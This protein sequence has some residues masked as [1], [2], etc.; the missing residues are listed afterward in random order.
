M[1]CYK[2][3]TLRRGSLSLGNSTLLNLIDCF[4]ALDT[5]GNCQRPDFSLGVSQYLHKIANLRKFELNWLSELR[6]NNG[7]N[8]THVP[9]C[10]RSDAWFRDLSWDLKIN[11]NILVRN[12]LFL[13]N[14]ITSEGAISFSQCVILSTA[15]HCL[16]PSKFVRCV[17]LRL[18]IVFQ[19]LWCKNTFNLLLFS[20]LKLPTMISY[21]MSKAAV[22]QFTRC[23]A[24][25]RSL[26]VLL[27]IYI[28]YF[29]YCLLVL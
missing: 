22:T 4:K 18:P 20:V 16:L 6:E 12:Y 26:F 24:L 11:S 1:P 15:L 14:Y 19:C 5:F 27:C 9:S 29:T 13:K 17:I 3:P 28:M 23:T 8:N 7:R 25:G 21:N 10:V 2:G